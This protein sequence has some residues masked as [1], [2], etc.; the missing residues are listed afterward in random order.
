MLEYVD[1][2]QHEVARRHLVARVL[3]VA[4]GTWVPSALPDGDPGHLGLF[5][6]DGLM[7]RDVIMEEPMASELVGRGDLLRPADA[8]GMS[9]PIPFD[10]HWRVQQRSQLAILD[11]E[12]TR[13]A[14]NWPPVIEFL[15]RSMTHRAHSLAVSMAISHLRHVDTR[16]LVLL[17]HLADRWG[18]VRPDGVVVPVKLTHQSLGQLIGARRPSV[19]TALRGLVDSGSIS[20]SPERYWV[21]HGDPPTSFTDRPGAS[22]SDAAPVAGLAAAARMSSR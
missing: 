10:V 17:W 7:T 20:R 3:V 12:F 13:R 18:R 8:D 4:P 1:P 14:A 5:V 15:L 9:A 19:T 16:L 21:L 6:L 2:G 22:S 11:A